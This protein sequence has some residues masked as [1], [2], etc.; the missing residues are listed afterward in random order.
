MNLETFLYIWKKKANELWDI[1]IYLKKKRWLE[2]KIEK[3]NLTMILNVLYT[4][5]CYK[6]NFKWGEWYI[7]SPD[8]MKTKTA[9]INPLNEKESKCF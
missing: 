9:I 2:K 5:K 8:W 7:D 4:I 3:Y 6:T 1:F